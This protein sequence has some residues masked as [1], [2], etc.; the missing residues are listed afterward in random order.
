MS[1]LLNGYSI[2]F[3][4]SKSITFTSGVATFNTGIASYTEMR[5]FHVHI[6]ATTALSV[7]SIS[8]GI[9]TLQATK[10]DET[11]PS[12]TDTADMMVVYK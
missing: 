4:L 8:N 12:Y 7:S 2:K 11:Y 9:A 10:F 5:I 6:G 1:N 3:L